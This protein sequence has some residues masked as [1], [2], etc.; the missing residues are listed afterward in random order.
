MPCQ[1]SLRVWR[2]AGQLIALRP[3]VNSKLRQLEGRWRITGNRSDDTAGQQYVPKL[4][5]NTIN[6]HFVVAHRR[7]F[8]CA[9]KGVVGAL[10]GKRGEL[11]GYPMKAI[12]PRPSV[13]SEG[14]R[15]TYDSLLVVHPR[16]SSTSTPDPK[17]HA[18]DRRLNTPS[19]DS[20]TEIL[21]CCTA[22]L[23]TKRVRFAVAK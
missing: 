10:G 17:G 19:T 14:V 1:P 2:K 20:S 3:N 13:R 12:T 7:P 11:D 6:E 21:S 4:R 22:S 5:T 8:A 18:G 9:V 23:P 15:A 16:K